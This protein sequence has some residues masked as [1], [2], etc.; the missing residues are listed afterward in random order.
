MSHHCASGGFISASYTKILGCFV[1][2]LACLLW[3]VVLV[4]LFWSSITSWANGVLTPF[5]WHKVVPRFPYD[6]ISITSHPDCEL[7]ASPNWIPTLLFDYW[8]PAVPTTLLV[9]TIHA[10]TGPWALLIHCH[11]SHL[12]GV[13]HPHPCP[14]L[15]VPI[16]WGHGSWG[17]GHQTLHSPSYTIAWDLLLPLPSPPHC[18]WVSL[19][20][21]SVYQVMS[22]CLSKL[23]TYFYFPLISSL[24][25]LSPAKKGGGVLGPF[26]LVCG[27]IRCL[28]SS[29]L[30]QNTNKSAIILYF[31]TQK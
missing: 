9:N 15:S 21:F 20:L 30:N 7:P 4:S 27:Y 17:Y 14:D 5:P 1:I 19:F 26:R 23:P 13:T 22:Y 3:E 11:L 6:R 10:G 28:V 25:T 24:W 2:T 31:I 18:F 16:P 8:C 29:G 12:L